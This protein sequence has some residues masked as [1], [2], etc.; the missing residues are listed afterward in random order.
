[1]KKNPSD[2]DFIFIGTPVW[3]SNYAP[4]VRTFIKT[5]NLEGKNIAIFCCHGDSKERALSLLASDIGKCK[6]AGKIDFQQ[7]LDH[8]KDAAAKEVRQW[9]KNLV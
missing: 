9:A 3:A 8:G 2:Y 7:P 5:F 1:L 6:I 4:A